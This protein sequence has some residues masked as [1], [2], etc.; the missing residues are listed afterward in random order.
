MNNSS[1]AF[2]FE[3]AFNKLLCA[4]GFISSYTHPHKP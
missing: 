3:I 1:E 2:V 4:D